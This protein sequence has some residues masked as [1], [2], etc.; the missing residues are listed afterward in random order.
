MAKLERQTKTMREE[1]RRESGGANRRGCVQSVLHRDKHSKS[2]RDIRIGIPA[3]LKPSP[4]ATSNGPSL[5]GSTCSTSLTNVSFCIVSLWPSHQPPNPNWIWRFS[6][7]NSPGVSSSMKRGTW[8]R[9]GS[10]NKM[11]AKSVRW[12]L[13]QQKSLWLSINSPMMHRST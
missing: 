1:K 4:Q 6:A 12:I 7:V 2:R 13:Y 5:P 9:P 3:Y 8:R 11:E 10:R